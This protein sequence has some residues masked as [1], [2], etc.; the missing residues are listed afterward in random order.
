MARTFEPH[1]TSRQAGKR[2][3]KV[4]ES[5]LQSRGLITR[6]R[7]FHSRFGEIDLIMQDKDALVFVEVR[8]RDNDRFGSGA[9]TVTRS[10][11]VK[12]A[13]AASYFLLINPAYSQRPCRFDVISIHG[14]QGNT[15][16]DWI[17]NAFDAPSR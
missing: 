10:K 3:E 6:K 17:K 5:F 15:V 12:L 7:N 1:L 8:F 4:A 2:W 14:K 9:E 11:Q 16:F 13:K